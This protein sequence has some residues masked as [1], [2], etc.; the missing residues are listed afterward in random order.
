[1]ERLDAITHL[2]VVIV[3]AV[4]ALAGVLTKETVSTMAIAVAVLTGSDHL[5]YR[6]GRRK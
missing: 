1:M 3:V 5:A 4:L 6:N 2:V